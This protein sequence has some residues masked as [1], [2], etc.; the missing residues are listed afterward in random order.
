[1]VAP[2][3][4]FLGRARYGSKTDV[5]HKTRTPRRVRIAR[6]GARL[7][8]GW[9]VDAGAVFDYMLPRMFA[10][11]Q[12]LELA[13]TDTADGQ[14]CFGRL[15]EGLA[16][17][18][19]GPVVVGD[20][21]RASVRKIKKNYL[22]TRLV[23]VLAP[24][25][26]RVAPRCAHFGVCGGCKWQQAA[27]DEQLR[28]KRKLVADALV[29]L[30]GFAD[31][32][33]ADPLPA[34]QV[35]GYRNKM[36]F[37]FGDRRYLL[38]EEMTLDPAA[39]GKP[40][41]FALGFHAPGRFDRVVDVDV[42]ELATPEMNAALACI[43]AWAR[44]RALP[45]YQTRTHEGFLR[46]LV[47]RH[48][49]TG[50]FM[51]YLVVSAWDEPLMQDALR[52]LR[53]DLGER[54]TTFVVGVTA[55]RNTVARGDEHHVMH[56][57][58]V[59]R[60]RLGDLSFAISPTSFFQTHTHQARRL[61]EE[62]LRCADV[63]PDQV[64]HDLY[65]GTGTITLFLARQARAAVGCEIEASALADAEANARVNGIGNARFV[66]LDLKHYARAVRDLPPELR[67]DVVVV[68]PP[69][70]GLHEDLVRELRA[71]RPERIV[72]VS[73]NPSSLGR[74]ARLLCAEGAY[75]L[76]D[77]QPVDLFP[78]TYHVESVVALTR[79]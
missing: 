8:V 47:V 13:I 76:G 54:L 46:N 67:P 78:H 27:Y 57:P 29:H 41:D 63:R 10:K 1:M 3:L 18:V 68:D 40:A 24:S 26:S 42:C 52:A 9:R 43:K 36:E 66:A 32:R 49:T 20:R 77:V 53:A 5:F 69:R 79:A 51:A 65:C 34:P 55:R 15:P 19:E 64:A 58:G 30:G 73:C 48:A 21:V 62:V 17:F 45:V 74:D 35:Y 37:S 23:E 25:P 7:V 70:A 28:L 60:E 2:S 6:E 44:R 16:V 75:R 4:F 39:L 50:E 31:A 38:E 56:G 71:L 59:I 14:K 33:V 11:G 61:Y 12:V 72:Y 22:E